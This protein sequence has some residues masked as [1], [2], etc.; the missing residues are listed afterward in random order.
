MPSFVTV[1]AGT[2]I[3]GNNPQWLGI[4][5]PRQMPLDVQALDEDAAAALKAWYPEPEQQRYFVM[6][7]Y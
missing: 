4:S 2:H 3:D 7:G 5:L 6:K 1:P